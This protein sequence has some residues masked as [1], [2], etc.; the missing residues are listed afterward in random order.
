ME[1]WRRLPARLWSD[2]SLAGRLIVIHGTVVALAMAA[3]LAVVTTTFDRLSIG[4]VDAGLADDVAEFKSAAL[5]R[6]P[7]QTLDGFASAYLARQPF[8]LGTY[9]VIQIAGDRV[10]GNPGS[11]PLQTDPQVIAWL[12]HPPDVGT[13]QALT[14]GSTHYRLRLSPITVGQQTLGAAIS[15]TDLTTVANE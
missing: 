9:M 11:Q 7:A 6:P 1:P 3:V 15:F 12:A 5:A 2:R 4:G 10:Q 14:L 8:E 13:F